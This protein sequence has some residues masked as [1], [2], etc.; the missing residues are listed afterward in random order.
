MDAQRE[1]RLLGLLGLGARGRLVVVGVDRV[2]EAALKGS[3]V[4]AVVAPDA[5]ANSR[6][7]LLPLLKARRVTVVEGPGTQALGEAVGKAQ[8]ATVGVTDRQLAKGIRALLNEGVA[9]T[10]PAAR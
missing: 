2:R 7:K 10:P 3:L 8:T 5:A 6:D 9:A 4:L 1:R